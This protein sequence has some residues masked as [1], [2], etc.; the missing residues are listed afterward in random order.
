MIH[1][2]SISASGFEKLP[3]IQTETMSSSP[4]QKLFNLH[5]HVK[6]NHVNTKRNEDEVR[7]H[8][9]TFEKQIIDLVTAIYKSVFVIWHHTH[10]PMNNIQK[11]QVMVS[12]PPAEKPA[13]NVQAKAQEALRNAEPKLKEI[14]TEDNKVEEDPIS[15]K[16]CVVIAA[17]FNF[18]WSEEKV[19]AFCQWLSEQEKP[20][21]RKLYFVLILQPLTQ[22]YFRHCI[23]RLFDAADKPQQELQQVLVEDIKRF[24]PILPEFLRSIFLANSADAGSVFWNCFLKPCIKCAAVL[25]VVH[26][27]VYLNDT[28]MSEEKMAEFEKFFL[29]EAGNELVLLV[30][31]CK[32]MI[33]KLPSERLLLKV[34]PRFSSPTI[35]DQDCFSI[36]AKFVSVPESSQSVYYV[37]THTTII[38]D[39]MV[40]NNSRTDPLCLAV[41]EFLLVS[42]LVR[43][44]TRPTATL[45]YFTQIAE[46][47]SV[48]GDSKIENALGVLS[49]CLANKQIKIEEL[50]HL[51]EEDLTSEEQDSGRGILACIS[52]YSTQQMYVGRLKEFANDI[53]KNGVNCF[54][55]SQIFKF[56]RASSEGLSDMAPPSFEPFNSQVFVDYY[57]KWLAMLQDTP[58][59]KRPQHTTF[60]NLLTVLLTRLNI[61]DAIKKTKPELAERDQLIH[62]FIEEYRTTL[63][64]HQPQNYIDIFKNPA[65]CPTMFLDEFKAA[66]STTQ[67]FSRIYRIHAGFQILAGVLELNGEKEIGADQIVPFALIGTV[68]S[69]PVGLATTEDFLNTVIQPLFMEASP[70]DH[71]VEYSVIQ[72]MAT[73][74]QI[75]EKAIELGRI[76][77]P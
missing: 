56:V 73:Y 44:E 30:S 45:E 10:V 70:V 41:R 49:D 7:R 6:R 61:L 25:G 40:A 76:T 47:S 32:E 16:S 63:L 13:A 72:F 62:D 27:E 69:N 58:M 68:Y 2:A 21:Q 4:A 14:V 31:K 42:K 29:S 36:A 20:L 15:L 18:L 24:A 59:G 66:F 11:Q 75:L 65:T 60:R 1:I 17:V 26:P 48:D 39:S 33:A 19:G 43:L 57:K 9:E 23:K 54:E 77:I 12:G 3:V 50:C 28:A 8:R 35:F 46:L 53:S 55:F 71:S 22:M 37:T 52:E 74:R 51:V 5:L 64:E 38:R 67:P 34:H